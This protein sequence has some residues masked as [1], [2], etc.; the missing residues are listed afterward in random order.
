MKKLI[1]FA[2]QRIFRGF[3]DR[4]LWDLCDAFYLWL[5]PR[6]KAFR[7]MRRHGYPCDTT[8][9]EWEDQLK[10]WQKAIEH[11]LAWEAYKGF[12]KP[13]HFDPEQI[14]KDLLDLRQ[15]LYKLWD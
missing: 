15:N 10:R 13:L 1:K 5:Y 4:E 12:K 2:W 6:L 14:D 3:S 11:Y 7:Q 9:R 8:A